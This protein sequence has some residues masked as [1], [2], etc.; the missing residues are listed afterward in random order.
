MKLGQRTRLFQEAIQPVGVKILVLVRFR[1]NG[2]AITSSQCDPAGQVF[3]YSH[4]AGQGVIIPL[5]G[6]PETANTQHPPD[7]V[8]I[9]SCTR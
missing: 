9:D 5:V 8:A 1:G 4:V 6:N 2:D 7:F 3:F